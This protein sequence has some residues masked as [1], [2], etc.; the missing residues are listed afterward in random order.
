MRIPKS[1]LLNSRTLRSIYPDV[2]LEGYERKSKDKL[3]L[4]GTQ[5]LSI[6]LCLNRPHE[7]GESEDVNFGPYITTL[8]REFNNHPLTWLVKKEQ[9]LA[10]T[11]ETALLDVCP[12]GVLLELE[13]VAKRFRKDWEI[14]LRSKVALC[15]FH[16]RYTILIIYP[17]DRLSQDILR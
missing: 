9:N 3:V 5:L 12:P 17:A 2:N 7:S 11:C 16:P 15:C 4:N 6:H 13:N 8:P 14:A 10:T 1:A